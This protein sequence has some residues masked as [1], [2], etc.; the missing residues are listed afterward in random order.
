MYSCIL[1]MLVAYLSTCVAHYRFV[2]EV[3][4]FLL[5]TGGTLD[6]QEGVNSLN[7]EVQTGDSSRGRTLKGLHLFAKR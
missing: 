2:Q 4:Q 3:I 7:A 1:L 5:A 6:S